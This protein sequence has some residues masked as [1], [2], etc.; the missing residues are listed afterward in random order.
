MFLES[1]FALAETSSNLPLAKVQGRRTGRGMN[2]APT[3]FPTIDEWILAR[4]P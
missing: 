1:D 2:F 4:A 3:A